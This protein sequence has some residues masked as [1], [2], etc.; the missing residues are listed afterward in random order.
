M[1]LADDLV[2]AW[3]FGSWEVGICAGSVL[4]VLVFA[5]LAYDL[6]GRRR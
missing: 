5:V 4:D 1:R 6:F 2:L 3:R